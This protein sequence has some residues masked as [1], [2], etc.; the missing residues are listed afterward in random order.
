MYNLVRNHL[1]F[2]DNPNFTRKVW[3]VNGSVTAHVR[4]RLGI[5]K[6][7]DSD[8]H[9]AID[10]T[11][12]AI[13]TQ[14][15]INRITKYYQ[16]EDGKFMNNKG[17]Y[18]DLETGE[19]L[20]SKKYEEA[21]GIY[22]PEPWPKFRKELDIRANC[23]TKERIIECLQ[24]EKIYTYEKVVEN[25]TDH[26]TFVRGYFTEFQFLQC[27]CSL[28]IVPAVRMFYNVCLISFNSIQA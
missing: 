16:Y 25:T 17:E 28:L 23:K 3:T 2:S 7:R 1:E 6:S 20:D 18:I 4:K 15:M 11:V 22:F 24:A 21:N 5:E 27:Y 19:I 14:N 26:K 8:T 9:H 10:A 12:I 13:T